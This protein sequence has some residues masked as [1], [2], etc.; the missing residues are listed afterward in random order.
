[1][2]REAFVTNY[3]FHDASAGAPASLSVYVTPSSLLFATFSDDFNTLSGLGDIQ[4]TGS[5]DNFEDIISM[6]VNNYGLNRSNFKKVNIGVLNTSFTIVPEAYAVESDIKSLLKFNTGITSLRSM[7]HSLN[8]TEFCFTVRQDLLN[9]FERTFSN[10]SIRHS[11]ALAIDLLFNH[12][13]LK[14]KDLFLHV[15]DGFIEIAV[16]EKNNLMF[17]NV[18]NYESNEDILYFLLFTMEQLNLDPLKVKIA[19]ACR[20]PVTDEPIRSIQKYIKQVHFCVHDPMIKLKGEAASL[21]QHYYFV[22]LNQ[23]LCEL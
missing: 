10:A 23:H 19:I 14:D 21:P 17:Y 16:K 20:R 4:I 3:Y 7:K 15:G 5:K 11:G 6:L 18:F 8:Q 1:M 12:H 22:L 13:S 9:Y 2:S